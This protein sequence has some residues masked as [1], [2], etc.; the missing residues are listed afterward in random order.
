[1]QDTSEEAQSQGLT[2][3]SSQRAVAAKTQ[4]RRY[5]PTAPARRTSQRGQA[6]PSS[7]S[8]GRRNGRGNRARTSPS[9]RWP[10]GASPAEARNPRHSA[11]NRGHLRSMTR[12]PRGAELR[13][14]LRS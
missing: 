5:V 4:T 8:T 12:H 14:S 3:D 7:R 11:R 10:N 2:T 6:T 13:P 1:M 9:N